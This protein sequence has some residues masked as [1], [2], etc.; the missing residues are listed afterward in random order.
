MKTLLSGFIFSAVIL[1]A[2]SCTTPRYAYSPSAQNVPVLTQKGDSKIGAM[3]STNFTGEEKRDGQVIDNRSRGIDIHGAYAVSNHFAVQA[4]YFARWERTEGGPDSINVSYNRNLTEVGIGYY[5]PIN[6]N[7]NVLFQ[8]F[9]GV[10]LG[11]FRFTDTDRSGY[12]FHQANITKVYLQ[13]AF[14]F[15]SQGSFTSAISIR[16]SIISYSKIKTSYSATQLDDY[17]LDRLS[18]REKIFIEP[19]FTGSFGFKNLPG[20]R[21]EFQGGLSFLL[22]RTFVD[23]RFINLSLGTWFDIGAI[24]GKKKAQ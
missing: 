16:G 11:S 20:I 19:A 4:Q 8:F 5:L 6:D 1:L 13:P 3:Y 7:G 15:R 17:K 18:S 24:I 10:G 2:V 12:N 9:A 23:Y 22:S 14:L 21:L